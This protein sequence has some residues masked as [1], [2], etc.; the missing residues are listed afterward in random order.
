MT[1]IAVN[2]PNFP[3]IFPGK[4]SAPNHKSLVISNRGAQ[5]ARTS[6]KSL[7]KTLQIAIQ[8][9]RFVILS[10]YQIAAESQR[11]ALQ[12]A[13]DLRF[14]IRIANRNRTKSRDLEHLAGKSGER[15]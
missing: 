14:A 15:I 2:S 3:R 7:S 6:P 13:S 11:R 10:L 9:A 8:I 5:I 4:L 12:I 1:L